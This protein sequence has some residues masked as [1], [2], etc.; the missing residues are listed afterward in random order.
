MCENEEMLLLLSGRLDGCNTP[1]EEARL[2][3]HLAECPDCRR[4]FEEYKALDAGLAGLT[5]KAPV[6]FTANVMRAVEAEP[7]AA[8]PKK[9][10][11]W[12]FGFGTAAA[13]IAAVLLLAIGSGML[14]QM[15]MG[16]AKM[17]DSIKASADEAM[18]EP[19][20]DAEPAPA[21]EE[22]PAEAAMEEPEAA[23]AEAMPAR[24]LPANVDCAAL[25]ND[26][27][28]SVGLLY[29]DPA[30]IPELEG[31]PSLPL[32][33]GM[34]YEISQKT[35][36]DLGARFPDLQIFEPEGC[37]PGDGDPAYLIVVTR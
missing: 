32:D 15:R 19:A 18:P 13:A 11:R 31:V 5:R 29:A 35:L 24:A 16:S 17:A 1:E 34:R 7:A 21:A 6:N 20:Y 33:G 12:T 3:I 9:N 28:C 30:G 36:N 26:E 23:F 2:D 37:L 22:A 10:R 27:N 25:A 14:P 4:V 8:A